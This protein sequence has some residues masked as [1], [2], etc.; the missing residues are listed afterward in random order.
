MPKGRIWSDEQL[1]DALALAARV[2]LREAAR[3]TG[4]PFGTLGRWQAKIRGEAR[5]ETGEAAETAALQQ[6]IEEK[7][8]QIGATL[9]AD[10]PIAERARKMAQDLY[11]LAEKARQ[12]LDMALTEAAAPKPKRRPDPQWA[13]VLAVVLAQSVDKAQLLAGKSTV[14]VESTVTHTG[15]MAQ[16]LADPEA[17]ELARL[18]FRRQ[19]GAQDGAEEEQQP[20]GGLIQ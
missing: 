1:A 7:G 19:G 8:E 9:A 20:A 5:D 16:V 4:I 3:L 15:D 18:L 2:G 17:R 11:A 6:A 10:A 12:Q 14:R 13:R